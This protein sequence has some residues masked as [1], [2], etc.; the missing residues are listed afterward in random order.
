MINET[1]SNLIMTKWFI[2]RGKNRIKYL[3]MVSRVLYSFDYFR[4]Q[5]RHNERKG[6]DGSTQTYG[7]RYPNSSAT[8]GQDRSYF[9]T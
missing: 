8:L 3:Y 1:V 2:E 4:R 7:T 9:C 6:C 5:Q